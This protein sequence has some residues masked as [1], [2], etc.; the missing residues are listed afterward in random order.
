ML[1]NQIMN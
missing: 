1:N